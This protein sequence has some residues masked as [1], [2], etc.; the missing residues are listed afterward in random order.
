VGRFWDSLSTTVAVGTYLNSCC[1][2]QR[3]SEAERGLVADCRDTASV[4]LYLLLD[5]KQLILF[6]AGI[7][8]PVWGLLSV[9][10]R[11]EDYPA[12]IHWGSAGRLA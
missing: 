3:A 4:Y 8:D 9:W 6:L 2:E 10:R 12:H 7:P 1:L 11:E 5:G